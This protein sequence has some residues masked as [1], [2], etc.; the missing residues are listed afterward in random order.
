[1]SRMRRV[2]LSLVLL[3]SC[4]PLGAGEPTINLKLVNPVIEKLQ[5]RMNERAARIAPWKE[6]GAIGEDATGLLKQF[7][8]AGQDLGQKKELH[9]LVLADNA[10]RAAL[11]RELVLINC[12][13]EKDLEAVARAYAKDRRDKAAPGHLVQ[14]PLSSKWVKK[15]DLKE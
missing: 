10:D 12:M 6:K 2:S 8:A 13:Q 7:A 11:F 14:D 3:V 5:A 9:D 4:G 15:Q 1:M